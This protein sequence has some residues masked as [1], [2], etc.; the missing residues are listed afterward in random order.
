MKTTRTFVT[1][2]AATAGLALT[3]CAP[4]EEDVVQVPAAEASAER[5]ITLGN[6]E[7]NAIVTDGITRRG[8]VFTVP[9]VKIERDG[10]LVM[11]PFRDGAPV[12][13]EYVGATAVQGGSND[14]VAIDVGAAPSAG[15]M[16]I[17]MLHFDMNDDGVFDFGD[18]VT[19][20]DAPAFEG[21]RLIAHPIAAPAESG[22]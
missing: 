4:Y 16:F 19:V 10:F 7:R 9:N 21:A 15:D 18:G 11:H 12:R 6:G 14:T 2:G 17:I 13:D 5:Q 22:G 1:L 3:A 20:P 8:S